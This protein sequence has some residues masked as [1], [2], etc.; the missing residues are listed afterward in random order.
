MRR[1]LLIG[2][3]DYPQSPLSGCVADAERMRTVLARNQDNSPNFD[4]RALLVPRGQE[5]KLGRASLRSALERHFAPGP[6]LAVLH[7]SGHG[8]INDLGGYIMTTDAQRYDE[9]VSMRDLL[10]MANAS[11]IPELVIFLDC[12]HSGALGHADAVPED[13]SVLREGVSLLT[14]SG[15]TQ[16]SMESDGGGLF[17]TLVC[18]AL[19]GA[20]A[21]LRGH[22]TVAG[23]YAHVH[24]HLDAWSQRPRLRASLSRLTPLRQ[25]R[26]PVDLSV[27]RKLPE[28]F[29]SA[30]D[31]F[32]LDPSYEPSSPP[33]APERE[34]IFGEL[35]Q[36]NR[37]NLLKPCDHHHMYDAAMHEG[38]CR[39]TEKGK[40][41]WLLASKGRL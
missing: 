16:V 11:P 22:V 15:S 18:D 20:A 26:P 25:C 33:H 19:N 27:L 6:D 35:Q 17:T 37:C 31:V 32:K 2:I 29:Q 4:C 7:F 30:D 39:L 5:R 9:G 14:A 36:L 41:C 3:D 10:V 1:A 8:C 24:P 34:A 12:C 38:E 13:R 40:H 23:V 21:D 28:F